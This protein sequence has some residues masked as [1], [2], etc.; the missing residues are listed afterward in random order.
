MA[1]TAR[2]EEA[3]KEIR[4]RAARKIAELETELASERQQRADLEL[5][6]AEQ[7]ERARALHEATI[8]EHELVLAR[9]EVAAADRE[10]ALADRTDELAALRRRLSD[11]EEALASTA[12]RLER[13]QEARTSLEQELE[14]L[15]EQDRGAGGS[16]HAQRLAVSRRLAALDERLTGAIGMVPT[17]VIPEEPRAVPSR[18]GDRGSKGKPKSGNGRAR[19]PGEIPPAPRSHE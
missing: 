7:S 1:T 6:A 10:A 17:I 8:A 5:R 12:I 4:P 2:F 9:H 3:R 16:G 11:A 13:A 19:R 18:K 15:L 14:V